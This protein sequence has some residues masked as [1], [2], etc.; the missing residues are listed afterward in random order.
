M[1]D[2]SQND[3]GNIAGGWSLTIATIS[4]NAPPSDTNA[5]IITACATNRTI[6]AG[7]NCQAAI[8]DLTGQVVATDDSGSVTIRQSPV[9]GTLVG[10]GNTVVTITVS[11]P[12]NNQATCQATIRVVDGSVP[13]IAAQPQ[14]VTNSVGS[15][16]TFNVTATSCSALGYQ[17]RFG[18]NPLPG[19]TGSTLAIT[20]IQTNNA[21]NYRVV[22]T[23]AAGSITSAVAVLT[24]LPPTA[25]IS[26]FTNT[27]AIAIPDSGSA[28]P[29][30]SVI[31]VA[32][33]SGVISNVAVT[34]RNINHVWPADID[35]LLV[36]P[37]GQ[38][39]M[40]FS[41]VGGGSAISNVTV[42]LWDG[43]ASSLTATGQI[44]SG[45]YK[46]TDVEPGESGELDTFPA[47]A[48]AGPYTSPLSVFNSL[49]PNGA[50]SLYVVDD[51]AGDA[52]DIAS[53]WSLTIATI[54]TN[55]PPSDT[56]APIITAC[57]TNRTIS[58]GANC[59]AAIPDLTGQVVAT[60]D[61]G[62]VTIRQSPVAGTLV[63]LGNTVVTI[64]VSD[65]ANNQ[66]TC[67]ATIR[68]VDGSVPNIAAQ[69]Q[70][71]TNSVGST[72]TFNVTATSCSALGYQW[73][74]GANPLP[75]ATSST[76]A[77]TNI[78]TNNAGNYRVVLTNAAGSIT[79]AVAVL[80]VL[81]PTAGISS[82]TNT[83]AI[84]IPDSGSASPYPSVINVAGMSGVISNV[85]VTLRNINHVW[86]ADIDVLLV[87]PAG[88]KAMIFS[89][90]GGGIA[91]SNVTVTL[92]DGAAS[93]LTATGQIVSGTY[94]P[95]DVE[96]G[97]SGELDTFPAPAPAGPYTSP[98]SVFNSLTPNGAWSLYVVDDTAGDAGDIASGW[99]LTIATVS[100]NA[101]PP[102]PLTI[103]DGPVILPNGHFYVSFRGTPNT[104]YTIKYAADPTGPWLTLTTI[105]SDTN[106]LIQIDDTPAP[107]PL[108]RFYRGVS[109]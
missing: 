59:Q 44:V 69:P 108:R 104:A 40:I 25:G 102:A 27:T 63:G 86:P 81:P 56:N 94:E 99:S 43:A 61:S 55:A 74:F 24:V 60:D 67:Q 29:Y 2:D 89:D 23:N 32:G 79:S 20:N 26:S 83:T 52:G 91:I 106:G 34:L 71:V 19:A 33:M 62:S 1:L 18:A 36:G 54:S 72:V 42:T 3:S 70:S 90:V 10:L 17:W 47:P 65:P 88:Q 12:A 46:P 5:P 80:T 97:E 98:L 100:T 51:T 22:L 92:W 30:P 15:T 78:Q 37:A 35:V 7:A 8:P 76:L 45:T 85:A 4:T 107:G 6:S 53:G 13:N 84:T 66:A 16:V 103:A 93:S 73:R 96:P 105:T 75:G 28:T 57:A 50:W 41:D 14:S 31:N 39:A 87:G 11:D 68:V 48:P 101:A 109:P 49:T 82:F 38:K 58:A 64:T 9:A 21:G 95:T 77:I